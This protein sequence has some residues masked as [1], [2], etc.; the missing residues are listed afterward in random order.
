MSLDSAS[1]DLSK[2][3]EFGQ[4]Y[5]AL[6]RVRTLAGIHLIGI[7]EKSFEMHPRV[8]EMDSKFRL[9]GA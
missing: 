8:I 4:G 5:V 1:I 7:N 6:S 3:F 2:T 9:Q